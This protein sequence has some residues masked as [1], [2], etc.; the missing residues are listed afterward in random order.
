M[1]VYKKNCG[2]AAYVTT[3]CETKFME[4]KWTQFLNTQNLFYCLFAIYYA[5][6]IYFKPD[7][8]GIYSIFL[9]PLSNRT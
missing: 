3:I 6:E 5:V 2:F 8:I 9:S 4:K 1:V 7:Y